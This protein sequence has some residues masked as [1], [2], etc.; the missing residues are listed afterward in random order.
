MNFR[1]CLNVCVCH[2]SPVTRWSAGAWL[3]PPPPLFLAK[4]TTYLT[5]GVEYAIAG[6]L[7]GDQVHPQLG[8]NAAGGYL[9]WEDNITDGDGLGISALQLDSSFSG[10]LSPFRVNSIGAGDQER[11]QVSLLN[12]GGAVFVWQ[13]GRPGIP[14][15]LRPVPFCGW[16]WSGNDV[17]VNTFTNN[18]RSTRRLPR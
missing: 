13:G 12:G 10:V 14:A 8:L 2:C 18:C 17:L 5:N 6:S 15:H 4:P 16:T 3:L 11:P 7:P 1:E 9:V